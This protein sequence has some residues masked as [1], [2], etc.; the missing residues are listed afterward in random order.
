VNEP[1]DLLEAI[2]EGA[3]QKPSD[4]E[5][6]AYLDQACTNK[7]A[8]R[9]QVEQLL[10]AHDRAGNFLQENPPWLQPAAVLPPIVEG[11]GTRIGP[12]KLL[13]LIGEG[14]M[15]AVYM[16]EQE[17]PVRRRVALK[18]IL[19]GMDSAQVIAR[20][21]AERQ[22]LAL[23]DHINIARVLD[24]GTTETG[25]PYFVMELVH[26]VPITDY[27]D[28][29]HL[30]PRERL[31]LFVPVC[32]AIQHAHQK[33][34]IHRDIKP[35]NVLVTLYDGKPVPKVIDFGV[36]KAIEQRLTER[37]M[38]TQYGTIVGTFEYM[39]PEQAEMSALGVDTRSDIY[40][41]GVLL[42][43][44]VTGTTPLERKRVREAGFVETVRLIKEEETPRPSVRISSS[45]GA[46]ATI[47]QQR[48]TEPAKLTQLVRGELDWIVMKCLEK[49]RTRRYETANALARDVQ[50]Y[51]ADEPVEA[52]PPSVGYKLRKIAR[53]YKKALVTGAA[54][55]TLLILGAVISTWQAVEATLAKTEAT[56]QRDDARDANSKLRLAQEEL[57]STLYAIHMNSTQAAWETNNIGRAREL[58]GLTCPRPCQCDLREFEW[59]YWN[60]LCH[61]ELFTTGTANTYVYYMALSPEGKRFA[62]MENRETSQGASTIRIRE[63][64]TGKELL[65]IN[66]TGW[67]LIGEHSWSP[68]GSR[69]AGVVY[70]SDVQPPTGEIKVWDSF[71]GKELVTIKVQDGWFQSVAFSPDGRFLVASEWH[72]E[73][74]RLKVWEAGSGKEHFTIPGTGFM[75][76]SPDG[77]R[78]AAPVPVA[79]TKQRETE[80]KLWDLAAGKEVLTFPRKAG[81][82]GNVVFTP[83]GGL[84]AGELTTGDP[85]HPASSVQIWEV[86]AGKE[87][88]NFP[89]L[90]GMNGG[91]KFS[92]DG[93][94]LAGTVMAAGKL[95]AVKVLETATGKEVCALQPFGSY[96]PV[97]AYSPDGTRL[98]TGGDDSTVKVWDIEP[99]RV[100][101]RSRLLLTLKGHAGLVTQVAFNHDGTRLFSSGMDGAVKVWDA[102]ARSAPLILKGNRGQP[103][104]AA[105]SPQ[106]SHFALATYEEPSHTQEIL[107]W[108]LAAQ[109][110]RTFQW[111]N[112]RD[113]PEGRSPRLAFSRDGR[114]LAAAT[115]LG[116]YQK[117]NGVR[118]KVW[119]TVLAQEV[120]SFEIKQGGVPIGLALSPDGQHL[121]WSL[122]TGSP[123]LRSSEI[124]LQD[125]A[126]CEEMLNI[127]E[128]DGWLGGVTFSPDG[129]R[130]AAI[131]NVGHGEHKIKVWDIHSGK[132]LFASQGVSGFTEELVF[133]PDGTR[134][135]VKS[136]PYA[137]P[138]EVTVWEVATSKPVATFKGHSGAIVSLAFSPDSRRIASVAE[139][140]GS[141]GRQLGE[142]KVWD[143]ATGQGLLTFQG[144]P[145]GHSLPAFSP[146]GHRLYQVGPKGPTVADIEVK[147]WDATPLP[148]ER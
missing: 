131:A 22:A 40:S 138:G 9:G 3:R 84:L 49:D 106:A 123:A 97:L 16:A 67:G 28:E 47:S 30:T 146:D 89:G 83:D 17:Q 15:G 65:A 23:M 37:T 42:Y 26:G 18:I 19:P 46:L 56:Q 142:V 4:Q 6:A 119:D 25:R 93:T 44:L 122:R 117:P 45:G 78:L 74:A 112:D 148:K 127:K 147:V 50:R 104:T 95:Q 130:L 41:L 101:G 27:C 87:L 10:K 29:N 115:A 14:G 71:S 55:L 70:G 96:T 64:A 107:V 35:S 100:E 111:L 66:V 20:F 69:I 94:R 143:T 90:T 92:P 137:R 121:A 8:L 24:A 38:F 126:A 125:L 82:V 68:D 141:P 139:P 33:G 116:T 5:R 58:L 86:A 120:C 81:T 91:P 99:R 21:E 136:S 113:A 79:G 88:L 77:K 13:Q 63:A 2:F 108:D 98:A 128:N 114:R 32:Q 102:T 145:A 11:P 31:E 73:Q 129:S 134:I 53:K 57:Q 59:H 62:S 60:R 12:Y 140:G 54:F 34:I 118:I 52:C 124:G 109:Q 132:E 39:S 76:L 105:L 135:A 144:L 1:T 61:T 133:S 36:A 72:E 7:P 110:S 43:E 75:A 51:L 80:V 85:R 103:T 48:G